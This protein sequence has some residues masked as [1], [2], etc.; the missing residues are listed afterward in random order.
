MVNQ[1]IQS[2]TTCHDQILL[3]N[4][5]LLDTEMTM[6]EDH[7]NMGPGTKTGTKMWHG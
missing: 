7:R 4:L 5:K 1:Y 6:I 2:T 3:R